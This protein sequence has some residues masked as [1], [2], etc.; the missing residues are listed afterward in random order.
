MRPLKGKFNIL[1]IRKYQNAAQVK[2]VIMACR[3]DAH[4]KYKCHYRLFRIPR[5]HDLKK[6]SEAAS[7][8]PLTFLISLWQHRL[9]GTREPFTPSLIKIK[10]GVVRNC[11][12]LVDL[13]RS[14]PSDKLEG[15]CIGISTF[16]RGPQHE[17]SRIGV[18][19]ICKG[20]NTE[21]GTNWQYTHG[22]Y[23]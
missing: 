12:I 18:R 4:A 7:Y 16:S 22:T 1:T 9:W 19:C 13:S 21:N 11:N 5:Q 8:E 3:Y 23:M 14:M 17:P 6:M 10:I 2:P 20:R 15:L